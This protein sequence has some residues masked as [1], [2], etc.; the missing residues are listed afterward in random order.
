MPT[1]VDTFLYP[2]HPQAALARR[3]LDLLL[4]ARR[5]QASELILRTVDSGMSIRDAYNHVFQ[6]VQY[7]L[8]RLWQLNQIT[9]AQEHFCTAATQLIMS[10]LYPRL[11][12]M[13]DNREGY[14]LITACADNELHEIGARFLTDFFEMAGW[15]TYYIGA[16][17]PTRSLIQTVK[18]QEADLVALSATMVTHVSSVADTID[19]L[20][21]EVPD[22][23]VMV[24]GS[25]FLQAPQLARKVGAD[26][27]ASNAEQAV[28]IGLELVQEARNRE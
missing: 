25:P 9:V 10:Q 13:S 28:H 23:P 21:A 27:T 24:G 3:Y 12:A 2:G 6:P 17:T 26:A 5:R 15:D 11:F 19:A 20:R 14:R 1:V 18:E 4:R 22:V 7:E 16:N 8:G